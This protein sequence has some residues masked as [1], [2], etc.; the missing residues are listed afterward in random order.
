MQVF[1]HKKRGAM[2]T[3]TA[4][5]QVALLLSLM[6]ALLGAS[7]I[8]GWYWHIPTLL[9]IHPGFAPV[10]FNTALGFLFSE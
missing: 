6:V 10:Q 5:Q 9:Q 8:V 7:V 4:R 1:I 2:T 3:M